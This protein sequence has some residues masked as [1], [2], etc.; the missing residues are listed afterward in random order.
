MTMIDIEPAAQ[1]LAQLVRT[2]PA[3]RL[4]GPTPC[5]AYTLGDLLE[6][7]GGL[8]LAFTAAAGKAGGDA[9]TQP[10]SGDASRLPDD[11]RER[12]PRDLGTM[13]AAWK[14]PAA[15]TG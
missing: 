11:W 10:P 1:R 6:H 4:D 7:T 14:D 12:I 3:G 15:W 8:A 5:T 2:V 9:V 13:G